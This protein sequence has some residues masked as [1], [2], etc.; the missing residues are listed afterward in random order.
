MNTLFKG[1]YENLKNYEYLEDVI[2]YFEEV[3]DIVEKVETPSEQQLTEIEETL[4]ELS[5]QYWHNYPKK[6]SG[7]TQTRLEAYINKYFYHA[8]DNFISTIF[9]L[10]LDG[11]YPLVKDLIH[12]KTW[13]SNYEKIH[14]E[15]EFNKVMAER[16]YHW[17]KN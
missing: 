9:T 1:K 14:F 17:N 8:E 6:I 2:R 15:E 16:D 5:D 10:Q 12:Y 7:E 11:C 3:L 4:Q 13:D